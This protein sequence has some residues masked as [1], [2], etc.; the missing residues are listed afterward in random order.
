MRGVWCVILALLLSLSSLPLN[1]EAAVETNWYSG[2]DTTVYQ[3]GEL[4]LSGVL[5]PDVNTIGRVCS[6]DC[7]DGNK[8]PFDFWLMNVNYGSSLNLDF[9]SLHDPNY[10]NMDVDFC[11]SESSSPH[12]SNNDITCRDWF[13]TDELE[14]DSSSPPIKCTR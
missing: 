10:V 5:E 14:E 1:V 4:V 8:D 2:S 11:Y 7:S 3:W 6:E 12:S 9:E 13:D